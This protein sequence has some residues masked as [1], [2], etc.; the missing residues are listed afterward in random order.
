MEYSL[1]DTFRIVAESLRLQNDEA[2][3][4]MDQRN[5][6]IAKLRDKEN[7]LQDHTEQF[8][9]K[10]LKVYDGE[11]RQIEAT[12]M[13]NRI[14]DYFTNEIKILRSRYEPNL[15]NPEYILLHDEILKHKKCIYQ[16]IGI[17]A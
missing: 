8:C 14:I 12:V 13:R 15:D 2:L 11:S 16:I 1:R 4:R 3:S 7:I 9:N 5:K 10:E 17:S 6:K